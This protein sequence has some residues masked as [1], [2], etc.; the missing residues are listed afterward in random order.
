V[1]NSSKIEG[2]ATATALQSPGNVAALY[3]LWAL[4]AVTVALTLATPTAFRIGGDNYYMAMMIP[5]GLVAL[6]ATR[7]AEATQTKHALLLIIAIA[8]LLRGYLLFIEPLLSTDIYRY[9]WDGRVQAAGINPYR[10][11]PAHEALISLRDT[12]IFPNINRAD[13]AVT[14]YPPVA[15][16]FF[17]AITR[18][19]ENI[20]VMR[21]GMLGCDAAT[22]VIIVSLLLRMG[23][24]AT[25]LVAYAWHPL[26]MW[27]IANNGHVDALMVA[28][29]MFG[30][31][32]AFA[33]KPLRGAAAIALGVLAKPLAVVALPAIWRPWDWK[34]PALVA[35]IIG[36]C[37]LPYASVGSAVFGFLANGYLNEEGLATGNYVWPLALWRAIAGV[38]GPDVQ[39]YFA[40][41]ALVLGAMAMTAAL[42]T[43]RSIESSVADIKRMLLVA[44]LLLSPN[45]PWYFLVLV[46]FVALSGGA[47]AWAATIGALLLQEEADWGEFVPL[48]VRKS[49]LYA[50]VLLACGY[51]IWRMTP[52]TDRGRGKPQ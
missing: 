14:I 43:P 17:F 2:A 37:Y 48:L 4:G 1:N 5:A 40:A 33:A 34:M 24:P 7:I 52:R 27:E 12:A 46:P 10:Y 32:L 38:V 47:P 25:R 41:A 42:R 21:L 15:Q 3:W 28:L 23:R 45:Y 39:I 30:L 31:W 29:M 6:A 35:A 9:V 26:P 19:G 49:V 11:V 13:Y 36:L 44:L 50:A 18:L 22:A 8:V 51:S 20:T 16:M